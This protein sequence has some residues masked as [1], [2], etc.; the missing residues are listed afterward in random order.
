M[1]IYKGREMNILD[2]PPCGQL[3]PVIWAGVKEHVDERVRN[4]RRNCIDNTAA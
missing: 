3:S 2:G 1:E 4:N